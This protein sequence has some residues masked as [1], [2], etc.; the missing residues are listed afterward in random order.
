MKEDGWFWLFFVTPDLIRGPCL[1]NQ[2]C[3]VKPGMTAGQANRQLSG[4]P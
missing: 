2:G 4:K 3:R 1:F